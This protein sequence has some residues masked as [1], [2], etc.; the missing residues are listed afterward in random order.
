M[1]NQ[2]AVPTLPLGSDST[3]SSYN[4]GYAADPVQLTELGLELTVHDVR[5]GDGEY[6][7]T[8]VRA[9]GGEE[10]AGVDRASLVQPQHPPVRS[11]DRATD[12]SCAP[13]WQG[14]EHTPSASLL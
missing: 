1:T 8:A 12:D 13:D 3:L 2:L 5:E 4:S 7:A 14:K 10:S 11:I 9:G 6:M